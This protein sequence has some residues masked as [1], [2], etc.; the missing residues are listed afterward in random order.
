MCVCVCLCTVCKC[1]CSVDYE[2]RY[3]GL[4]LCS[5]S[6]SYFVKITHTSVDFNYTQLSHC[7]LVRSTHNHTH[8]PLTQR[9]HR[10]SPHTEKAHTQTHTHTHTRHTHTH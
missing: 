5:V 9:T 1:R 6:Q 3:M 7:T 4:L 2:L 8:A 10:E